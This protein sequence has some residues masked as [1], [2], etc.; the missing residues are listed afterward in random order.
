M[1]PHA[2]PESNY[3]ERIAR[4]KRRFDAEICVHDLPEIFHYWSNRH[5]RAFVNGFGY[6]SIDDFFVREIAATRVGGGPLHI[7]SIGC[8]DCA[9]EVR[10]ASRLIAAG[11][12]DFRFLCL[13]ISDGA[14]ARGRS[15]AA[16]AGLIGHFGMQSH[17]FNQ[18]LPEGVFDVVMA[19][20]SL[21]HVMELER[22]YDAIRHQLTVGGCFLVSDMIGRNGHVRWPEARKLVDQ[23]WTQLPESYRYNWQLR[24]HERRFMDWDCSHEGFEGVRAQDV[25]PLLLERFSPRVFLAWGNIIDVFIDRSFGHN[26]GA[27]T[28]WD[29]QFVDRVHAID[30]QAI[31]DGTIKPTHLLGKFQVEPGACVCPPGMTPSEAIR[32]PRPD[33]PAPPA[34]PK[35]PPLASVPWL[36]QYLKRV[37]GLASA[38]RTMKRLLRQA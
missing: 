28:E 14:L 4:E 27:L 37:P 32:V 17:D 8:G 16:D 10:I 7:A 23:L 6:D 25:L 1:N 20:Q 15:L 21:H 9:A 33:D 5:L 36:R 35:L 12:D 26:F 2:V 13:D 34:P 29:R 38:Y 22:L 18:G 31:A 19:N 24:R 11:V 3:D 30:S